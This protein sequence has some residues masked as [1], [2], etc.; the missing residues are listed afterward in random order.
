MK[1]TILRQKAMAI[2]LSISPLVLLSSCMEMAQA[3]ADADYSQLS[4]SYASQPS[5]G[6]SS[7]SGESTPNPYGYGTM[8]SANYQPPTRQ[9]SAPTYSNNYPK[10]NQPRA[11]YSS[12]GD[13][14]Y[15]QRGD[16][17]DSTPAA[18]PAAQ[19]IPLVVNS[20]PIALTGKKRIG[21]NVFTFSVTNRTSSPVS[22]RVWKEGGSMEDWAASRIDF[23]PG[24][25]ITGGTFGL[26]SGDTEWRFQVVE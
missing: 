14:T 12:V 5:T 9:Y 3:L 26:V 23:A 7:Y 17:W 18:Q 21:D 22:V 4:N 11:A 25:T 19:K 24:E 13:P 10:I 20:H 1:A 15:N 16:I 6:S 2:G 8:R